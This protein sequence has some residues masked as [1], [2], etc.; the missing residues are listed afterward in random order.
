MWWCAPVIPALARW[1]IEAGEFGVDRLPLHSE[2]D[3]S[4][5]YIRPCAKT[6]LYFHQSGRLILRHKGHGLP[7]VNP[8]AN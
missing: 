5:L 2:F 6:E 7:V 1:E 4:L 3:A 8:K